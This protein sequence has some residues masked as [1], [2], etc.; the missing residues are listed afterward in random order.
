[1]EKMKKVRR[2]ISVPERKRTFCAINQNTGEIM[3]CADPVVLASHL[4]E[5][6]ADGHTGT[7]QTTDGPVVSRR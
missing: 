5:W 3:E 2:T 4:I 6:A 7:L 1:M